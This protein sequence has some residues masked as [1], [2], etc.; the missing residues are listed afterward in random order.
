MK[1]LILVAGMGIFCLSVSAQNDSTSSGNKSD[2][3]RIGGMI[4]VKKGWISKKNRDRHNDT[5][6]VMGREQKEKE[7]PLKYAEAERMDISNNIFGL[8][9][10][11]LARY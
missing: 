9:K 6:I 4:I 10:N 3:I 7:A 11:R 1:K 5:T 8:I 2:T